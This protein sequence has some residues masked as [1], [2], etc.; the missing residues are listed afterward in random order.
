MNMKNMVKL[1]S[2]NKLTWANYE[3][4]MDRWGSLT[5]GPFAEAINENIGEFIGKVGE[6]YLRVEKYDETKKIPG[7]DS[8]PK[9]G[10][11]ICVGVGKLFIEETGYGAD[12]IGVKPLDNRDSK[13]MDSEILYRM[14][15]QVVEVWFNSVTEGV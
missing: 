10:N 5:L 15:N 12:A 3:R 6:L 8:F 2:L 14:N 7:L 11:Y 1:V 13:W 9:E 4:Q